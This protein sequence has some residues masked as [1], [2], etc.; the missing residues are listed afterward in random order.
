MLK[1]DERRRTPRF[2]FSAAAEILDVADDSRTQ[3]RVRDLSLGGCYVE[4]PDPLPAGRN[5]LVEIYTEHEFL[6]THATVTFLESS[7]G[8]GLA[9]SVMQPF[10]ADVL[11]KWVEQA[12][13]DTY[14]H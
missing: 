14:T 4:T 9:F 10:F 5:V 13:A 6:E 12:A 2:Q 3:T 7:Q 11:H 1:H 8:M